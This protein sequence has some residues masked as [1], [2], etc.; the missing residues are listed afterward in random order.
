MK[1]FVSVLALAG[2]VATGSAVAKPGDV[3][4]FGHYT[5]SNFNGLSSLYESENEG[6]S[7]TESFK[8]EHNRYGFGAGYVLDDTW[9]FEL[10]YKDLGRFK[11]SYND[12]SSTF[13]ESGGLKISSQALVL[14]SIATLPITQEFKLEG[15]VGLAMTRSKLTSSDNDSLGGYTEYDERRTTLAPTL[16]LGASY[17]FTDNLALFGRYEYIHN[18]ISSKL[19]ADNDGDDDYGTIHASTLDLGVRYTF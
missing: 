15:S 13:S 6:Y 14:R 1:R 16:G 10:G 8:Q 9:S 17:A 7:G 19:L 2:L 3:Y 18:A 5:H 4:L 11:S 12:E